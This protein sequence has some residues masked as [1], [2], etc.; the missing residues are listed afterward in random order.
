[1]NRDIEVGGLYRNKNC[2]DYIVLVYDIKWG[3]VIYSSPQHTYPSCISFNAFR[4]EYEQI[5]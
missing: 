1:M 4:I 5:S 2:P 3:K